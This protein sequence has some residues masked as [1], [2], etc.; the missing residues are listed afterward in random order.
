MQTRLTADWG[1]PEGTSEM[2]PWAWTLLDRCWKARPR[3]DYE[4]VPPIQ[5]ALIPPERQWR[6]QAKLKMVVD[7]KWEHMCTENEMANQP[8][9]MPEHVT[10]R[11]PQNGAGPQN[12]APCTSEL[13][14]CSNLQTAHQNAHTSGCTLWSSAWFLGAQHAVLGESKDRTSLDMDSTH[15]GKLSNSRWH[16]DTTDL[17]G[18]KV[19]EQCK[20]L[21]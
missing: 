13:A 1:S 15:I 18:M 11:N 21:E 20:D 8:Q 9:M 12:L 5:D 16:S 2:K 4:R 7:A 10:A 17:I 19:V 3:C 14:K 6:D